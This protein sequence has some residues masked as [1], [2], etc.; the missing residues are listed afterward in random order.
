M[1]DFQTSTFAVAE[2]AL[3]VVSNLFGGILNQV[4]NSA[5]EVQR[6]IGGKAHDAA[7][8][9]A[10]KEGKTYFHQGGRCGKGVS[11]DVC[12]NGDPGMGEGGPPKFEQKMAAAHPQAEGAPPPS[13]L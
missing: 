8:E 2:T 9:E 3:G 6:A 1:T 5:Y 11:P 13:P 10:V 7:L 12:W 4:N